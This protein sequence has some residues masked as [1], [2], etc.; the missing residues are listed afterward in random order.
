[1]GPLD[2]IRVVEFCHGMTN[3]QTGQMLADMGADVVQVEQPSGATIRRSP[4]YVM[5]GRGKQSIALDLQSPGDLEIIH[6]LV[7]RADV[8]LEAF[9][10]GVA[11]RLGIG[12]E[13]L[14]ARNPRLVYSSI[15]GWG[16]KSP[17][18]GIKGYEALVMA[19]LGVFEAYS[20]MTLR[21]GPS[22]L[23]TP[24]GSYSATQCSVLGIASALYER[25]SSGLGQ[26]IDTNVALAA[27]GLDPW[28]Q[29]LHMMT[30]R[31]P[32][33]FT[34]QPSYDEQL[35]PNT[36]FALRL[37]VAVT[38]DGHWLQFS[39][40]Q[41]RLFTA[42]IE[43]AGLTALLED[44]EWS[45]APEFE[46]AD[47]R[48]EFNRLLLEAVRSKSLAEWQQIFDDNPNVFAETFRQGTELLDHPQMVFDKHVVVVTDPTLGATRQPGPAVVFSDTPGS[49]RGP[50]PVIDADRDD[51]LRDLSSP[52]RSS[53]SGSGSG[54]LPQGLPLEGL[55]ILEL[56]TFYAGPYG[57]TL[58]TD[59]GAR[60]IKIEPLEGD[61]MRGMLPFPEVGSAKV[62]QGKESLAIDMAS[63]EGRKVVHELAAHA[64]IAIRSFR[65]GVAERL[66]VDAEALLAVNPD[67]MYLDA[68][69]FGIGGPYGHRPAFAPTISAGSGVAMRNF[70]KVLRPEDFQGLTT[71]EAR[72]VS[73]QLTIAANSGGTQPDGIAA[74]TVGAALALAAFAK[75]RGH[76][77]QRIL[78]TMLL[79]A[80]HAMS[81]TVVDYGPDLRPPVPDS[82]SYGYGPL[83]R[84]YEAADGWIFLAAPAETEWRDLIIA[85]APYA[86]ELGGNPRFS[87]A[88]SRRNN[89]VELADV[90]SKAFG[91]RDAADWE[92]DLVARGLG[93]VKVETD[94][95]ESIY[96]GEFGQQAGFV[97]EAISPVFDAYP[98][99]GP[100]VHFSRS[101]T[102]ALPGCTLGQHSEA[103][104]IELGYEADDID[105]LRAQDLLIG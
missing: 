21:D 47:K 7:D 17:L 66:G 2:G 62:L 37:L 30:E 34:A 99:I 9:Q 65:A 52:V 19:K 40:V 23:S 64:D 77:G 83:Y 58:L 38:S 74:V 80:A 91:T 48:T 27:A 101:A 51:V 98:R 61:P 10:P 75:K 57:A 93:C 68:P 94:T 54:K 82:E 86:P 44:P 25:E 59:L 50:A 1:M 89:A 63:D 69:G 96:L 3:A 29:M 24:Y 41:P 5:W 22:F 4:G 15:S 105:K 45:S 31:Y 76:G 73:V 11:D 53:A 49:V 71:E 14:S 6:Q 28:N 43:E 81:E 87:D 18:S 46:D 79:S 42:M 55:T 90:L 56:G 97:D 102:Q 39:Q 85:M 70:G 95:M 92:H 100:L 32:D 20:R 16:E 12:Y 26:R 103:I 13:A 88:K 33:A 60:V 78:T 36:S 35:R 72:L 8:V 104:L 84:L 67:L